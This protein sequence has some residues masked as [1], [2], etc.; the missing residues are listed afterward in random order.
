VNSYYV[1]YDVTG[2]AG[3]SVT[4]E[5]GFPAE[6]MAI[7]SSA[8]RLEASDAALAAPAAAYPQQDAV[9]G[10]E[11]EDSVSLSADRMRVMVTLA[12]DT[13]VDTFRVLTRPEANVVPVTSGAVLLASA[14]ASVAT[15]DSELSETLQLFL[16]QPAIVLNRELQ[17]DLPTSSASATRTAPVLLAA[18]E[19]LQSYFILYDPANSSTPARAAGSVTFPTKIRGLA[20]TTAALDASDFAGS[21]A[22]AYPTETESSRGLEPEDLASVAADAQSLS[23]DFQATTAG[24]HVRV[25]TV[26]R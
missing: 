14:P 12:A 25:F 6:V 9:R 26:A 24:D 20:I 17:L 7:I 16:E 10:L 3:D 8:S 2:Q 19:A 13:S 11:S 23:L 22:V 21:E 15:G 5:I 4:F 1:H 18:G